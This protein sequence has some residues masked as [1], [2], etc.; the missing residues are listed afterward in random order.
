MELLLAQKDRSIFDLSKVFLGA[1]LLRA[2][3]FTSLRRT[4]RAFPGMALALTFKAGT[5]Y[6]RVVLGG[7]AISD[8]SPPPR[9]HFAAPRARRVVVTREIKPSEHTTRISSVE[10]SAKQ[11][12]AVGKP[13][14]RCWARLT[15][16]PG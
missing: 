15:F 7:L 5:A 9:L 6:V 3:R 8:N 14:S 4:T 1:V 12:T 10:V 2:L 16:S 13:S 11:A